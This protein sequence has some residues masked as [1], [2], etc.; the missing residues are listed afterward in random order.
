MHLILSFPTETVDVRFGLGL[1]QILN[2]DEKAQVIKL[3]VWE[4]HVSSV[5]VL[6]QPNAKICK[7][8]Q[9]SLFSSEADLMGAKKMVGLPFEYQNFQKT[10]QSMWLA[11]LAV[12][13]ICATLFL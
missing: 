3:K 13:P 1:R 4:R 7:N 2:V 10:L 11:P 9:K 5:V 8:F 6:Q 12:N